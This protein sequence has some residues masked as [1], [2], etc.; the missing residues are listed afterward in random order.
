MY[1]KYPK[2]IC[3]KLKLVL[4]IMPVQRYGRISPMMRKVTY[5]AQAACSTRLSCSSH[6]FKQQIWTSYTKEL[7]GGNILL[8]AVP[9][10]RIWPTSSNACCK[11]NPAIDHPASRFW[12]CHRLQ[13]MCQKNWNMR[14]VLKFNLPKGWTVKRNCWRL[15]CCHKAGV[16]WVESHQSYQSLTMVAWR[17]TQVYPQWLLQMVLL[18]IHQKVANVML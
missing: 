2:A 8:W 15:S 11:S 5:G 3:S 18:L 14:S 17:E 10:L 13:G 16:A 4:R 6:H 9:I 7:L 1:Q 12:L